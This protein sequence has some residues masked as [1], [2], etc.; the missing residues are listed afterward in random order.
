MTMSSSLLQNIYATQHR[1]SLSQIGKQCF[2]DIIHRKLSE[3]GNKTLNKIT[4][5]CRFLYIL[6]LSLHLLSRRL[7]LCVWSLAIALSVV[8]GTYFVNEK[9]ELFGF[10]GLFGNE[11][12]RRQSHQQVFLHQAIDPLQQFRGGSPQ[13]LHENRRQ[14][15]GKGISEN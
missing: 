10:E 14:I 9:C 3:H 12:F 1:S 5:F 8:L 11:Q 2:H 13:I 4:L 6:S 15:V 7:C